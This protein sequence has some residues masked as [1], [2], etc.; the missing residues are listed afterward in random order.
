MRDVFYLPKNHECFENADVQSFPNQRP[1]RVSKTDNQD[2][3]SAECKK[4]FKILI[5]IYS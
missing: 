4:L 3:K 5:G 1:R 2:L